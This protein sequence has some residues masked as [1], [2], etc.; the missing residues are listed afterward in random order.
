MLNAEMQT[1]I[2]YHCTSARMINRK[3]SKYPIG[4]QLNKLWDIHTMEY[5]TA[6][7]Y[8]LQIHAKHG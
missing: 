2:R 5:Y 8:K 6:R 7:S 1:K 4:K 3:Q